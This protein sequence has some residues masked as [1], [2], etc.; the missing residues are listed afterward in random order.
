[1]MLSPLMPLL[2]RRCCVPLTDYAMML[3]ILLPAM[4]HRFAIT[5]FFTLPP[6]SLSCRR[7]R[8]IAMLLMPPLFF[9]RRHAA[10]T[11]FDITR[12]FR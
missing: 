11:L 8:H 7:C 3:A 12:Y 1:M 4:P 2:R 9:R 5:P 10:T 6:F